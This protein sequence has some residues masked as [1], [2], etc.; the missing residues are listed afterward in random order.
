MP[1]G[2]E[3]D[4]KIIVENAEFSTIES[5][6]SFNKSGFNKIDGF[7]IKLKLKI[8]CEIGGFKMADW[9]TILQ[10]TFSDETLNSF[11]NHINGK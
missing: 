8:E 9:E 6:R 11:L 7:K 2:L 5:G 1:E 4:G 3:I 10:K